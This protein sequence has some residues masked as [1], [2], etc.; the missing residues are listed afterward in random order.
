[1]SCEVASPDQ[2][3]APAC[4]GGYTGVGGKCL[5]KMEEE[6]N[7]LTA[8]TRCA[9]LGA[10]LASI[11]TQAEQDAVQ[12]MAGTGHVWLGLTDWL[13]EGV[14]SWL[15]G[16]AVGFTHWGGGQHQGGHHCVHLWGETGGWEVSA[17]KE[18]KEFVCQK[19]GQEKGPKHRKRI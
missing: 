6:G 9:M 18:R 5:R 2:C 8:L 15:D 4:E 16:S 1:M 12:G 19:E 17:C 3:Q 7:Y 14:F 11:Q 13:E 10:S